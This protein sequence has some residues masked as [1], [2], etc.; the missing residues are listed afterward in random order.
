M[1]NFNLQKF[2]KKSKSEFYAKLYEGKKEHAMEEEMH[3]DVK[4][5]ETLNE[6]VDLKS[7]MNGDKVNND[8]LVVMSRSY[9]DEEDARKHA[10]RP[11]AI[12]DDSENGG[13]GARRM[14]FADLAGG[15]DK[16]M[17]IDDG[18][19]EDVRLFSDWDNMNEETDYDNTDAVSGDIN[20][21]NDNPAA[22]AEIGLA[23]NEEVARFKKLAGIIK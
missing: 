10:M 3:D 18:K 2:V 15:P 7:L 11:K 12:V 14:K 22:D 4:E 17:K 23:L 9:K 20:V 6:G 5:D 8:A 16:M 21:T 1:D 13:P 19:V